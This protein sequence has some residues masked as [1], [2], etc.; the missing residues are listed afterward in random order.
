MHKA[1][2]LHHNKLHQGRKEMRFDII[3]HRNGIISHIQAQKIGDFDY[4]CV[5]SF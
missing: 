3:I 1:T 5:F 4:L 2:T